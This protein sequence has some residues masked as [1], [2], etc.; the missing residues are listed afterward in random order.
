LQAEA[1]ELRELMNRLEI[2]ELSQPR[3]HQGLSVPDCPYYAAGSFKIY[4]DNRCDLLGNALAIVSGVASKD[5]AGQI[6]DFI[7][8]RC[9]E[10]RAR[11]ELVG[12]LPP[13]FFPYMQPGDEDWRARYAIYNLPGE[14]HNGGVWPFI[15]GFYV[16]ACIAAGR[17]ELAQRKLEALA[18]L[19]KPWHENECEWGFN[20]QVRAQTGHPIGRDW[21]TWSAG[22][23]IYACECVATNSTPFFGA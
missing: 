8:A 17:F 9:V 13:C 22:M 19:V 12:E 11:G 6:I 20:E 4:H 16:A 18:A 7:E 3:G 10:M 5:R 2:S 14:Y 23:F 1:D 21:Q 15:C